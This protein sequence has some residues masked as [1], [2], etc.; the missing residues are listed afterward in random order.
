MSAHKGR[1]T[2]APVSR[3]I[4]CSTFALTELSAKIAFTSSSRI[5][6]TSSAVSPADGCPLVD[7]DGITAPITSIP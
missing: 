5:V 3:A 1:P 2:V 6:R 7:S 4:A